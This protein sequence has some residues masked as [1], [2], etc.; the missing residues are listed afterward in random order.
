MPRVAKSNPGAAPVGVISTVLLILGGPPGIFRRTRAESYLRPNR[1]SQ[2]HCAPFSQTFGARTL[3]HSYRRR[4]VPDWAKTVADV[5][6]RQ[7]GS[8]ASRSCATDTLGIVKVDTRNRQPGSSRSR[9]DAVRGCAREP[10][11]I[12]SFLARGHAPF[13]SRHGTG[14]GV[15]SFSTTRNKRKCSEHD[16]IPGSN[17]ENDYEPVAVPAGT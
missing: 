3:S 12:P 17:L 15:G 16:Y 5:G 13:A 11:R 4:R 9:H 8:D 1:P 2:E 6:A 14:Q 7:S 10:A